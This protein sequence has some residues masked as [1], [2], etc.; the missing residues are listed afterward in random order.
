VAANYTIKKALWLCS[1]VSEVFGKKLNAMTIFSGNQLAIALA[2]D[3]QFY[4]YTKHIDICYH[5]IH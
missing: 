3:C 4:I 2:Q 5:F 1:S